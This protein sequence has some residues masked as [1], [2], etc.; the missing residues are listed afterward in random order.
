[1]FLI[2]KQHRKDVEGKEVE[3][4]ITECLKQHN[5]RIIKRN[6]VCPLAEIDVLA[7]G[8]N[9]LI[10]FIEIKERNSGKFGLGRDAIDERK[11]RRMRNACAYYLK[12]VVKKSCPVRFDL[13]E[14]NQGVP[15]YIENIF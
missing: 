9:G 10:V 6:Y 5:L 12:Y 1:M 13:I 4:S 8:E 2:S 7:E 11:K 14:V 3:R 15:I